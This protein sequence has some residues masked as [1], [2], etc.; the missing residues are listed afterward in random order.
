MSAATA[1]I[2]VTALFGAEDFAWLDGQRRA[3]FPADRNQV[4]AHC[5]LF[6]QLSATLAPELKHRLAAAT[7]GRR[8]PQ[9]WIGGVMN[10]G[11][12]VAYRIE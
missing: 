1:P 8:P 12:G 5:T 11:R 6:H 9:A 7:R 4:P 2:I 10:L 3:H